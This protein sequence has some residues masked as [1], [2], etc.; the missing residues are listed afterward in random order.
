MPGLA[1]RPGLPA[2]RV[3]LCPAD[4]SGQLK[5]PELGCDPS[6]SDGGGSGTCPRPPM[7]RSRRPGRGSRASRSWRWARKKAAL[8]PAP[9]GN[10]FPDSPRAN[11]VPPSRPMP[12]IPTTARL[13]TRR[14]SLGLP[15]RTGSAPAASPGRMEAGNAG[16]FGLPA[17]RARGRARRNAAPTGV[18]HAAGGSSG[19]FFLLNWKD[20]SLAGRA[21]L[22]AAGNSCPSLHASAA[23]WSRAGPSA[24]LSTS[25]SGPLAA[26]GGTFPFG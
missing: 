22:V 11:R 10:P 6:S 18:S 16:A 9:P 7:S 20:W 5:R 12:G 8:L 3:A 19:R 21:R 23:L 15:R 1:I 14:N 4:A 17:R 24:Y 26:G 25:C 2:P 13:P